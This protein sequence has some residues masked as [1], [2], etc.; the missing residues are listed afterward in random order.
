MSFFRKTVDTRNP[1]GSGLYRIITRFDPEFSPGVILRKEGDPP[2]GNP[3]IDEPY[4]TFGKLY[5]FYRKVFFRDSWDNQG[6]SLVGVLYNVESSRNA[7]ATWGTVSNVMSFYYSN[8][9]RT[10][11]S[12]VDFTVSHEY[13]HAVTNCFSNRFEPPSPLNPYVDSL[14]PR[15]GNPLEKVDVMQQKTILV[16]HYAYVLGKVALQYINGYENWALDIETIR[17][18]V[19]YFEGLLEDDGD[20]SRTG[21][22]TFNDGNPVF[23]PDHVDG[24]LPMGDSNQET[25]TDRNFYR[26]THILS[27]AFY[28]F[29]KFVDT[30][31]WEI[32]ANVWYQA[33]FRHLCGVQSRGINLIY[34][35]YYTIHT[36]RELYGEEIGLRLEWCWE[37]VGLWKMDSELE[38]SRLTIDYYASFLKSTRRQIRELSPALMKTLKLYSSLPI[39]PGIPPI[40]FPKN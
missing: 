38:Y 20:F 31:P 39:P 7:A 30:Y 28:L 17:Y 22:L 37:Q 10:S 19:N 27:R 12:T 13:A 15:I 18:G 21:I 6:G 14:M 8:F 1:N 25:S 2:T 3:H 24:I 29:C 5:D 11:Y 34:F 32:P 9:L 4:D 33:G 35:A 40:P 23:I 26:N 36:A 16:E